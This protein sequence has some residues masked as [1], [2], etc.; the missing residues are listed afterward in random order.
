VAKFYL[1]SRYSRI[2]ELNRYR[3]HLEQRGHDVPARWL[4][5]EHQVHGIEASKAIEDVLIPADIA[6]KFATD[7][8]N[9]ILLCDVMVNF[10]EP[11]R[12]GPTRGGRHVEFGIV[13]ALKAVENV[14]ENYVKSPKL[15]VIGHLENIFHSLP[16]VD[17]LFND[18]NEFLDALDDG[19]VRL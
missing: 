13:L 1:A 2:D 11:S 7:D 4:K 8:F 18:F 9:D 10:T 14:T 6:V 15:Y 17:G 5:G 16:E 12:T 19:R 3:Q